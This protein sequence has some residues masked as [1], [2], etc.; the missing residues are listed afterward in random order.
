MDKKQEDTPL[1]QQKYWLLNKAVN[2]QKPEINSLVYELGNYYKS[3]IQIK[4][5]VL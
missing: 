5:H 2:F 4:I 3:T 1:P